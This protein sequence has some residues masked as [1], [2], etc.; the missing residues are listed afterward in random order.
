MDEEQ[1][2]Q[3]RLG[4]GEQ[5]TI[6]LRALATAGYRWSGSVGGDDP[7]AVALEV[8]RGEAP[9]AAPPGRSAPE[10]AV[11]RGVRAGRAVVRLEQRRSWERGPAAEVV[12]LDVEVA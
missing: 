6:P 2:R 4:I 12:R 7:G 1:P 11:V 8:R 9:A 10:E 5:R 3:L